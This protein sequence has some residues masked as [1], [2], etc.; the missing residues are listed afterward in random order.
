MGNSL[1]VLIILFV[2]LMLIGFPIAVSL[3]VSACASI[4][5]TMDVPLTILVEK[6]QLGADSYLMMSVPMFILGANIMNASG[7]SRRIFDMARALVGSIPG[8]LAHANVIASVVFGGI[9]GSAIADSASLGKIEIEA[10]K[11]QGYPTEY[12]AAVTAASATIGPIFPPSIPLVLYAGIASESVGKLFLAGIV[13]ALFIAAALMV[14]I[15]FTA[16]KRG[17]PTDEKKTFKQILIT[18]KDSF[19]ATLT[20]IIILCGIC[21]GW[22]TPTESASIV[23]LYALIL[24]LFVFKEL[25]LSMLPQILLETI[26]TSGVVLLIVAAASL[27]SWVLTIG[28]LGSVL[29]AFAASVRNKVLFLIA[30][31]LVLLILGM[32]METTA[33][34]IVITPF[35]IPV[36]QAFGVDLIHFGVMLVLNLMIGLSTP[37]FG[38]GLFTVSQVAGIPIE[39]NVKAILPFI[40]PMLLILVL[41]TFIPGISTWLPNLLMG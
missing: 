29:T 31:N 6:L 5:F 20:P 28:Q 11:D 27:F 22:F 23:V 25:K 30:I 21:F 41:V 36:A 14:Q 8:A 7:V 17:F 26:V 12:A 24:G 4:F 34:L 39:K 3:S 38:M 15:S 32:V 40:P 37:P 13:P 1:A 33:I 10:M 18:F 9:S 2:V 19:F 16:K 35:L